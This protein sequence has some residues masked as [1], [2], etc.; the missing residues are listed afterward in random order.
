MLQP[1]FLKAADIINDCLGTARERKSNTIATLLLGSDAA[2]DGENCARNLA[3]ITAGPFGLGTHFCK[4]IAIGLRRVEGYAR[5]GGDRVP[6]VA[7]PTR[8][9]ACTGDLTTDPNRRMRKL[10]RLRGEEQIVESR[11]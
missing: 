1:T 9:F 4:P 7:E 6:T 11:E 10:L 8:T 3:R 2:V 5:I